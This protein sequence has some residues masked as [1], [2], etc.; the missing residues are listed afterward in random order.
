MIVLLAHRPGNPDSIRDVHD[1]AYTVQAL[2]GVETRVLNYE[3]VDDITNGHVFILS[4]APGGHYEAVKNSLLGKNVRIHG[5]IPVEI[6][7]L[8]LARVINWNK[9]R[10]AIIVYWPSHRFKE[11]HASSIKKAIE[12]AERITRY[13]IIPVSL[14]EWSLY[15]R[16]DECI[17]SLSLLRGGR[18]YNMLKKENHKVI[19]GSLLP[20]SRD[21]LS[22]WITN[23]VRYNF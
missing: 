14:D 9:C 15:R 19:D 3:E 16:G 8:H 5:P 17:V 12:L 6:L 22:V 13:N 10:R 23:I 7:S 4:L 11:R 20:L 18:L 1:L 2:T 21:L